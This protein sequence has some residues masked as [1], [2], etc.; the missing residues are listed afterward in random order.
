MGAR[1]IHNDDNEEPGG[2]PILRNLQVPPDMYEPRTH[3]NYLTVIIL[4]YIK[5]NTFMTL[6]RLNPKLPMHNTTQNAEQRQSPYTISYA[7][8]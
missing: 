4:S 8:I 1:F 3:N 7:Y 2:S 5:K 6:L